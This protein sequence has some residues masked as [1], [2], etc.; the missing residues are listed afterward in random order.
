MPLVGDEIRF[1]RQESSVYQVTR[2]VPH[3]AGN[4]SSSGKTFITLDKN[5]TTSDAQNITSVLLRRYYA[6]PGSLILDI[7]KPAGG[8]SEGFILP[9]YQVGA[10]DGTLQE[11][12]QSL[13]EK[14]IIGNVN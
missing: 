5:L 13:R 9:D 2:V 7:E 6:N 14:G 3:Y 4:G 12:I 1:G 11:T 8:T 10:S